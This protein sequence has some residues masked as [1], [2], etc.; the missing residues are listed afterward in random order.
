MHTIWVEHEYQQTP[1]MSDDGFFDSEIQCPVHDKHATMTY[2]TVRQAKPSLWT[3]LL[4]AVGLSDG[5]TGKVSGWIDTDSKKHCMALVRNDGFILSE[6][7]CSEKPATWVNPQCSATATVS[8]G[9]LRGYA[10]NTWYP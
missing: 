2:V 8:L 1:N 3:H 7:K 9:Y 10:D 5:A 6:V 4:S